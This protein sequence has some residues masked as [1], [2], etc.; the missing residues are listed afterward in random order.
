VPVEVATARTLLIGAGNILL[1][2][3][4]AGVHVVRQLDGLR[5]SGEVGHAVV[6]CDGGTLG[7]SLLLEF[8]ELAALIAIDA[9]DLGAE[10]GTVQVFRGAD[11][12]AQLCGQKR[13]A[14]EVALADLMAAARLTD[15]APNRRALVGIQPGS[16]EWGLSPTKPVQAAI[17]EACRSVLSLLKEWGDAR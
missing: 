5:Q 9:M 6:L 17:S 15:C 14:H 3:D 4:G 8:K 10:P 7:L 11:M 16:T 1:T 2:D 13:T 12:D